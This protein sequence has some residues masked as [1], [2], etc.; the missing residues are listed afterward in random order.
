MLS[1]RTIIGLGVGGAIIAIGLYS[2]ITSLGVQTT[3]VNDTFEIGDTANYRFYAPQGTKQFLEINGTSFRVTLESPPGGLQIR[4][5]TFQDELSI[6]WVHLEDGESKLSI[7]NTGDSQLHVMGTLSYITEFIQITY[8][9]MVI[10]A[11][12]IIIGFSAGFSL[13]K[14]QGF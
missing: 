3:E 4:N 11:G 8:H 10:I 12:V 1:K 6:E 7:T 5:E 2:L 14:P 9:I 13:R